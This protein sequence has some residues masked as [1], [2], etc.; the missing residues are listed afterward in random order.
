MTKLLNSSTFSD[1]GCE[2]LIVRTIFNLAKINT[3]LCMCAVA[4][5]PTASR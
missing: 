5:P 1:I 4:V 2:F 3:V